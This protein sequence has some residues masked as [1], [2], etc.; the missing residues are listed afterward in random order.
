[1]KIFISLIFL[2]FIFS[3]CQK[4]PSH[5]SKML[6]KLYTKEALQEA[7]D[8]QKPVVI[9]FW[10]EWCPVCHDLD[11]TL[12]SLPQIQVKLSQVIALRVDATDQDDPEVQKI[13][14]QY[15]I[16]GLPTTVFLVGHGQEI[17]DARLIGFSTP[18]DFSQSFAMLNLLK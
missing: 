15:G 8:H 18:Q 10:A 4:A 17:K 16:E 11:N 1:M 6:W 9:D 2:I 5:A 14:M 7:R 13:L 12:F 3:S